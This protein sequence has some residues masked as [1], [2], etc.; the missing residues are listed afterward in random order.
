MDK[1]FFIINAIDLAENEEEKESVVEYVKDH[2]IKYGIRNPHLNTVSSL[3]A[4]KEKTTA[5]FHA[6]SG[7][8][9]FEETFY[10]FISND[11]TSMAVS[12]AEKELSRVEELIDTLIQNSQQDEAQKTEK[13]EKSKTKY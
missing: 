4:L 11:L 5:N 6:A 13:E 12:S 3:L 2:L 7:M 10:Q 8:K 1:M 9:R